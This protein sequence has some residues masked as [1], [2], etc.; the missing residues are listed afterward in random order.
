MRYT[1]ALVVSALLDGCAAT[2]K[3]GPGALANLVPGKASTSA[4]HA[5]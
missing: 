1:P 3:S 2:P 5:R 4:S